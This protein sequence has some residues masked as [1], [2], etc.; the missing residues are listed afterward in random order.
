MDHRATKPASPPDGKRRGGS[1][2]ICR[3]D[4]ICFLLTGRRGEGLQLFPV[5]NPARHEE[6]ADLERVITWSRYTEVIV[7]ST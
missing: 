4:D 3:L 5:R 2:E 7:V 6:A 1:R